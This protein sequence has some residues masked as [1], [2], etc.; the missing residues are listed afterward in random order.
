MKDMQWSWPAI[1][2]KG[3]NIFN[4]SYKGDLKEAGKNLYK[5]MRKIKNLNFKKIRVVK[6]PNRDIGIAIN[7]RLKKAAN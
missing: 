2:P 6:I 4:L 7:D 3:K 1:Y 5:T